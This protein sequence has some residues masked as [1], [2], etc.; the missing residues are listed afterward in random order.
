MVSAKINK[1]QKNSYTFL[2]KN[3]CET[4]NRDIYIDLL[5]I[6]FNLLSVLLHYAYQQIS[7]SEIYTAITTK[8]QL[9][10][11]FFQHNLCYIR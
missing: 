5:L 9:N 10:T 3:D 1:C 7:D 2:H 4:P 11:L 6:N 8:R